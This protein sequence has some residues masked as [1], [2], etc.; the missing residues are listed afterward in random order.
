MLGM[1]LLCAALL[2]LQIQM[3]GVKVTLT[4]PAAPAV[5][6][7]AALSKASGETLQC[8]TQTA[9]DI[10]VLQLKDVPLAEAMKRIADADDASWERE[11]SVWRLVRTD[12]DRRAERER[13]IAKS[14]DLIAQALQT[15]IANLEAKP[16]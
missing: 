9:P 16:F 3:P 15:E 8:S 7:L 10:L 12:A 6:V 1:P 4:Q 5:K 2:S 11:G 13:H 14:E